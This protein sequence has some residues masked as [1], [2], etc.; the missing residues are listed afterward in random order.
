MAHRTSTRS[1]LSNLGLFYAAGIWGLTFVIIKSGLSDIAPLTMLSYRFLIAGGLLLVYCILTRKRITDNIRSA[2]FMSVMLWAIHGLQ[3]LGL[4]L[5]TASNSGFI[6]G[7][8]VAFVPLFMVLIF[9]KRPG[10]LELLASVISV[11]GLWVLTGGL[12][13]LN[14]GDMLTFG[15]AMAYALHVLYSDKY[16]KQG[17]DPL[18]F[19]CQQFIMTGF[20]SLILAGILGS[21]LTLISLKAGLTVLFLAVLPTL[22]AFVIQ[23]YSQRIVSPVRVSLIFATQPVFAVFFAL[24]VGGELFVIH[25]MIGGGLICLALVISAISGS[26]DTHRT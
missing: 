24:T 2:L 20:I 8:F 26:A 7:L 1:A 4:G 16:M 23:M 9:R 22:S 25:R 17:F 6:T 15:C 21:S 13:D 14:A 3:T 12:K 19:S 11:C 18:L 5:T 10:P